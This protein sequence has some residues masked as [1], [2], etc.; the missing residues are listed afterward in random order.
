M[1]DDSLISLYSIY[2][3]NTSYH[4][5]HNSP[6][7][8]K[9]K[10]PKQTENKIRKRG[11]ET[12]GKNLPRHWHIIR[13]PF[14]DYF[15]HV[16]YKSNECITFLMVQTIF[17]TNG[18]NTRIWGRV[19]F[20]CSI[21]LECQEG[22]WH[23]DVDVL[24]KAKNKNFDKYFYTNCNVLFSHKTILDSYAKVKVAFLRPLK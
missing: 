8:K 14:L 23:L 10:N 9:Q 24:K 4:A 1:L 15:V 5:P 19:Y 21:S 11:K 3:R 20:Y 18:H 22:R 17:V 2:K 6:I 7:K 13:S 16:I 12:D